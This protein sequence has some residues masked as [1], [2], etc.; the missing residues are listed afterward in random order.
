LGLQ[1]APVWPDRARTLEKAEACNEEAGAQFC[2]LIVFGED[3]VPGC[4]FWVELTDGARFVSKL[5]KQIFA[6][7]A[8]QAVRPR[9]SVSI[10]ICA[11]AA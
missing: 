7:Y 1:F 9:A 6:E 4:P 2:R 8:E 3:L 11:A 5:Q 10:P